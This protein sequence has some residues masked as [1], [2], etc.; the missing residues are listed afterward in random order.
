MT[1]RIAR[2]NNFSRNDDPE[3]DSWL[4]N[5]WDTQNV[6]DV[7]YD[8]PVTT[9]PDSEMELRSQV[10]VSGTSGRQRSEIIMCKPMVALV[11]DHSHSGEMRMYINI[12]I[13]TTWV[14]TSER[15][16]I[17]CMKSGDGSQDYFN[18]YIENDDFVYE[19]PGGTPSYNSDT[20]GAGPV[21]FGTAQLFE[22]RGNFE[23][24]GSTGYIEGTIDSP[25]TGSATPQADQFIDRHTV[26]MNDDGGNI[27][28]RPYVKIGIDT[29]AASPSGVSERTMDFTVEY[30]YVN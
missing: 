5:L 3:A 22:I 26:V 29:L 11:A 19:G 4:Q 18:I 30:C 28:Y 25:L 7:A 16:Q 15:T 17:M 23:R 14:Q 27:D 6:E 21:D 10:K 13:P 9:S 12:K 24:D 8:H 1:F 20:V 2:V